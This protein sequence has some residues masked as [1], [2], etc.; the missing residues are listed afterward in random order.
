MT[1]HDSDQSARE[2]V[3]KSCRMLGKLNLTKDT[4]GH[5]SQRTDDG[6]HLLV[7]AKGL[8]EVGVR[9][10]A[11]EHIVKVDL[12]GAKVEG[13]DGL[14]PPG[15]IFIHTWLYRTRPEVRSVVHIHP[16]TAVLFT[17]CNK[18]LLP[19]CGGY[20]P[21]MLSLIL[22]GIPTYGRSV[23]IKN[24]KL[25]RHFSEAM[26]QK[27]AC[28]MRGHGITTAGASVE[29]ATLTAITLNEAAEMNYRAYLLGDPEPI[30]DEDI[31]EFGTR[32]KG[33]DEEQRVAARLLRTAAAAR[34]ASSWRYYSDLTGA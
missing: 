17:I 2:L 1:W 21:G 8:E 31:A 20:D 9:Y 15:E 33:T 23:T 7:R 30:S 34:T 3:A 22:D 6:K 13:A 27:K 28:L 26:G 14:E 18:Q 12:N 25:G 32:K 4:M 11:P 16:L 19:L 29:E 10:T 24:D 5:V